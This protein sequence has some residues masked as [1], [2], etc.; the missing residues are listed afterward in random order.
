MATLKEVAR[1]ARVSAGTVSHVLN[2]NT[3]VSPA[4][5][6]RVQQAIV[7]LD[8]HPDHVARSLKTGRTKTVGIVIPDIAN[9]FFPQII[10][11]A[12]SV[13]WGQDY[14]LLTFNTDDD[15]ERERRALSFLRSRRADGVLLIVAPNKGDVSHIR[16]TVDAGIAVVCLDRAPEGLNEVDSVSVDDVAGAKECV[17]HLVAMGH[18]DI[19]ML[20]G[21]LTLSNVRDRV[22]GYKEALR[23]AGIPILQELILEGDFRK[24]TGTRLCHEA[25]AVRRGRPTALFISNMLMTL[26]ALEALTELGVR[27]PEDVAVATFDGF[28]L[29]ALFRPTITAVVQPVYEIGRLGAEMLLQRLDSGAQSPPVHRKLVTELQ[30]RESTQRALTGGRTIA[31]S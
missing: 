3:P 2:G 1:R 28:S 29:P 30:V 26:G 6:K 9:P 20:T 24:G 16:R 13:L 10:R 17:S 11:G 27:C 25:F 31:R 12:E 7:A 23:E 5:R 18:R 8:Y 19:A 14:S 22:K 4:L 15:L 21:S